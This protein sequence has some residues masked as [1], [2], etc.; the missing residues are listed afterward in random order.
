ML[1]LVHSWSSSLAI[2]WPFNLESGRADCLNK[3]ART[4]FNK[5]MLFLSE[6]ASR[7]NTFSFHILSF[8]I[9][10]CPN[11][12]NKITKIRKFFSLLHLSTPADSTWDTHNLFRESISIHKSAWTQICLC[13]D[14]QKEENLWDEKFSAIQKKTINQKIKKQPFFFE[15]IEG[16]MLENLY[17]QQDTRHF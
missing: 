7:R 12:Q 6:K 8:M 5:V 4:F 16:R 1:H 17:F 14:V 11:W 15:M 9:L 3:L 13:K 10:W 2:R